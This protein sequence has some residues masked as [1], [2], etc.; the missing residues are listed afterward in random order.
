MQNWGEIKDNGQVSEFMEQLEKFVGSL[1][2]ATSNM[3]GRVQLAEH[4]Y[5]ESMLDTLKTAADFQ[6][7]GKKTSLANQANIIE[8]YIRVIIIYIRIKIIPAVICSPGWFEK[9]AEG[10]FWVFGR[11]NG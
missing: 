9:Y 4:E 11:V 10:R 7:A 1:K 2:T 6:A 5:L 8:T 3:D